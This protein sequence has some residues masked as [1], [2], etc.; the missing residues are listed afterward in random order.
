MIRLDPGTG[1]PEDFLATLLTGAKRTAQQ[2]TLPELYAA[3]KATSPH[4]AW[5]VDAGHTVSALAVTSPTG[6][7]RLSYEALQRYRTRLMAEVD[8]LLKAQDIRG[9]RQLRRQAEATARSP[10]GKLR[11]LP[12]PCW[13]N[14]CVRSY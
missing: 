5:I 1:D 7:V 2:K 13:Q 10:H 3:Q 8:Q 9:P 4:D 6:L 11:P 12:I 14:L